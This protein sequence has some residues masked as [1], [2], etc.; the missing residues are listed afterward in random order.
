MQLFRGRT[1]GMLTAQITGA[2]F[3]SAPADLPQ[4]LVNGSSDGT[5]PKYISATL[6]TIDFPIPPDDKV[7]VTLV[8]KKGETAESD[9]IA[10]P[11]SFLS[12]TDVEVVSYEPPTEDDPTSSIVAKITGT[13]FSDNL[14]AT[15]G[16][17]TLDVAVR[18]ATEAVIA[19][20]DP[21]AASIVTLEDT[22]TKQKVKVVVTRKSKP[23]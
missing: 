14:K 11:A 8:S 22:V 12:I 9:S 10:N 15:F 23:K 3:G 18:S 2:G 16:E 19:I 20:P 6:L 4:V 13:G 21:K 5:K 1:R 17:K 7:R